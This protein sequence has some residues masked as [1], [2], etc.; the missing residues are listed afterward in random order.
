MGPFGGARKRAFSYERG[1]PGVYIR[2]RATWHIKQSGSK[3]GP[4]FHV[5]HLE[6][7]ELVTLSFLRR[8]P[9]S[10]KAGCWPCLEPLSVRVSKPI[11]VVPSPLSSDRGDHSIR[12][13]RL[14]RLRFRRS[15]VQ[16]CGLGRRNLVVQV[17]LHRPLPSDFFPAGKPE[18]ASTGLVSDGRLT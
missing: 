3:S 17:A 1:N 8:Q 2:S 14:Q 12:R 13:S 16:A 4:G 5:K 18:T 7:C 6:A 10:G 9:H 11:Q 15:S